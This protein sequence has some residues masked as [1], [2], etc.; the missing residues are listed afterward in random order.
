MG[1][2]AAGAAGAAVTRAR[3]RLIARFKDNGATTAET[4]IA[5]VPDRGIERRLVEEFLKKGVL[6]QTRPGLYWI[7]TTALG[8]WTKARRRRAGALVGAAVALGAAIGFL[9]SGG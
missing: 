6:H 8:L 1:G 4:A 7:D 5:Y 2:A 9:A 3:R